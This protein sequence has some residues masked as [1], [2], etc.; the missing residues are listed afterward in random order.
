MEFKNKYVCIDQVL[1]LA[2]EEVWGYE[3]CL[4]QTETVFTKIK[5]TKIVVNQQCLVSSH[6][7]SKELLGKY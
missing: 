4:K 3:H 6:I 2:N 7:S 5:T 1:V